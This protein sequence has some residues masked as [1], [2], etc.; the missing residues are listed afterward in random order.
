MYGIRNMSIGLAA[1]LMGYFGHYRA[2]GWYLLGS[3][4]VAAVDGVASN[5]ATGDKGLAHWAFVVPAV[6]L[7]YAYLSMSV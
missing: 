5:E 4:A 6:G 3:S 2:L 1:G 7:A